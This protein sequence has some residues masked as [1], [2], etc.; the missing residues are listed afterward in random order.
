[1]LFG[2]AALAGAL[3]GC[4]NMS[5]VSIARMGKWEGE[6]RPQPKAVLDEYF[7]SEPRLGPRYFTFTDSTDLFRGSGTEE[8][9]ES[10]PLD[11]A[12]FQPAYSMDEP[13]RIIYTGRFAVDVPDIEAAIEQAAATAKQL[14]GYVQQRTNVAVT[15]RVPAAKFD[16][17]TK[18]VADLGVVR[19]KRIEAQDVTEQY[20][21]LKL[22]LAARE[23]YLAQLKKMLADAKDMKVMLEI[24]RELSGTVEEI[25]RLKGKLRYLTHRV[26]LSTISIA[27]R[28]LHGRGAESFRLP[29]PWLYD[30]GLDGLLSN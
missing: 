3:C 18:Q 24:Q 8:V 27:F 19:D 14:G 9:T 16:E 10:I 13:R 30:L 1:V 26:Q 20:V 5:D 4:H 21:D 17:A 2:I 25:E 15:I 11:P 28:K 6:D 22:R 23:A 29:F 12:A 7:E